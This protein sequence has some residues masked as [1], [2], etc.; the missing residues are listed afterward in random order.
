MAPVYKKPDINQN[1]LITNWDIAMG[2][3]ERILCE[4]IE[5]NR[6]VPE[7]QRKP[8]ILP[9]VQVGHPLTLEDILLSQ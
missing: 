6:K 3:R 1:C 9:K 2:E 4:N 7:S 8:T 5:L